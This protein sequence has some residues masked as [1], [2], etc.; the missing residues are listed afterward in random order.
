MSF[1][2]VRPRSYGR[3]RS[4]SASI[5]SRGI[6]IIP[7]NPQ[8][9]QGTNTQD[10]I[11]GF[12]FLPVFIYSKFIMVTQSLHLPYNSLDSKDIRIQLLSNPILDILHVILWPLD[13]V[14]AYN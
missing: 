2:G 9:N 8:R 4:F 6:S 12:D 14:L 11:A 7:S 5:Q 3:D 1:S 13:S 10:R